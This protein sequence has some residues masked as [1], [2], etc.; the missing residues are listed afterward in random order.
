MSEVSSL[1]TPVPSRDGCFYPSIS[2]TAVTK[3]RSY[4][5]SILVQS[6]IED[7]SEEIRRERKPE[8]YEDSELPVMLL[9]TF[10]TERTTAADM[11][12][13]TSSSD[14]RVFRVEPGK[15][16]CVYRPTCH[17][18]KTLESTPTEHIRFAM[19]F[20]KF[21]DEETEHRGSVP[22]FDKSRIRSIDYAEGSSCA[23]FI[24]N[25]HSSYYSTYKLACIN[26]LKEYIEKN[27][28]QD[29]IDWR[30]VDTQE[31]FE[32]A[33]PVDSLN[34]EHHP[35]DME[36]YHKELEDTFSHY[37]L[38]DIGVPQPATVSIDGEEF[39]IPVDFDEDR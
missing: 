29:R 32:Q 4:N 7:K 38:G 14:S 2:Y 19:A 21:L 22:R 5:G 35:I 23:E 17:P 6:E 13:P 31:E 3:E 37:V 12:E 30:A 24:K 33:L 36:E 25:Y 18:N 10:T 15:Y 39:L 20:K 27:D 9:Y 26:W 34:E 8:A 16:Y 28:F 1:L 11:T